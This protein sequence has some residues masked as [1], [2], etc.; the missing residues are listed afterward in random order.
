MADNNWTVEGRTFRTQ[1]DYMAGCRDKKKI[2]QIRN[3]IDFQ[4]REAVL[5][6]QKE[7]QKGSIQFDTMIGTDFKDE[8]DEIV[9]KL[10]STSNVQSQKKSLFHRNTTNKDTAQKKETKKNADKVIHPEQLLQELDDSLKKEVIQELKKR[11]RYRKALL[12]LLA[13]VAVGSFSYFI[14]YN[15]NAQQAGV[16]STQ[17]SD[18]KGDNRFNDVE[19]LPETEHVEPKPIINKYKTLYQM[20]KK[21]I[22]WVKIADTDIDY[23]VMQTDNATYYLDHNFEQEKDR[24]GSIFMDPKCDAMTPSTNLIIYGHN[25]R[26]GKMFGTLNSYEKEAYYQ[27]HKTIQFDTIYQEGTYE[28]M[29]AF[30]SQLYKETD[31]VFKYYQFIDAISEEE[32]N[33]NMREMQAMSLYDTGVTASYGDQLLTLS[34]CDYNEQNGRFV[35]VAKRVE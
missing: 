11:E 18:L 21:L 1:H 7:L 13:V 9:Q 10:K 35:V 6:L 5:K 16:D 31:I 20:N 12:T 2:D 17:L 23:P 25:M 22:G 19:V 29:Y 33:S 4:N 14:Y 28:V 34:T 26:S 15:F 27:E 30:R 8:V 24:N 3:K 32:F